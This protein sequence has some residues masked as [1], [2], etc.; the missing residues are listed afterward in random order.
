MLSDLKG[1]QSLLHTRL[2][3]AA[4]LGAEGDGEGEGA[5]DVGMEGGE[6]VEGDEGDAGVVNSAI[7]DLRRLASELEE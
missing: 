7:E 3:V 5:R 1:L 6:G 2:K 4:G